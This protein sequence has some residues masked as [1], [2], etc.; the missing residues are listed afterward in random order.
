MTEENLK[1]FSKLNSDIKN[2][3]SMLLFA[4]EKRDQIT[5][6]I[7][8]MPGGSGEKDK[9]GKYT[10]IIMD[11]QEEINNKIQEELKLYDEIN[12]WIL[13]IDDEE[14]RKIA[15]LKY[16]SECTWESVCQQLGYSGDGSTQRKK[17]KN[18]MKKC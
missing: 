5:S 6:Y 9:I 2:L 15:W 8:D 18:F 3:E 11:I 17:F 13:N 1:R 7:T 12:H 4:D 10:A 14:L 16:V